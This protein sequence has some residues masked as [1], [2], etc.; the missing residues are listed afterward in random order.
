MDWNRV[1]DSM[2]HPVVIAA[3][4]A[5][6]FG[7]I[8]KIV[9]PLFKWVFP[10]IMRYLN[11]NTVPH[12]VNPSTPIATYSLPRRD[13]LE[14]I[15]KSLSKT[16][17]VV[18]TGLGGI[19]KTQLASMYRKEH[20]AEYACNCWVDASSEQSILEAYRKFAVGNLGMQDELEPEKYLEPVKQWMREHEKWLF[21][22]DNADDLTNKRK[23]IPEEL[24]GM[25]HVLFT[26]REGNW[27]EVAAALP[28]EL[29]SL[30]EAQNYFTKATGRGNNEGLDDLIEALG[31]LPLAMAQAAAFIRVE[32]KNHPE[33]GYT[34]YL[35]Q[36]KK[37]TE[38]MLRKYPVADEDKRVVYAT[39]DISME[40]IKNTKES[41]WQLLNIMAFFAPDGIQQKW[42]VQGKEALPEPLQKEIGDE[43]RWL[44]IRDA[45]TE[46]SLVEESEG[47]ALGMHRLVGEVVRDKLK[48]TKE[49]EAYA[50]YAVGVGDELCFFDF[51]TRER[52]NTFEELYPHI[53][54]VVDTC[55]LQDQDARVVRL[56]TFLG[57][58]AHEIWG[59]YDLALEWHEKAS[60][61]AEK[62]LRKEHPD[63]AV[64]YN[65]IAS[66]YNNKGKYD[67]ALKWHE[68]ALVIREKVLGK[69]HSDT[70][71]TYNN[72]AI[73][74]RN[75]GEHNLA[76]EWNEKALVIREKV[77]GKEHPLT[78]ATYNNIANVYDSKSEHDRALEWYQKAL[79]I[80]EKVLGKEHPDTAATYN[81]IANVYKDK[82]EH[83]RALEWHE[84]ALVIAEDVLGKE[85]PHTAVTY[86]NI[87]NAYKNKGEYDRALEGYE[88]ALP[89]FEKKLG[90][91]HPNTILVRN[92]IAECKRRMQRQ[93]HT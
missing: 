61:I 21:V 59:N 14:K 6:F 18:L 34:E 23:W 47:G 88:K 25:R 17:P 81:N 15:S 72:I 54:S 48:A 83:D 52:R 35:E 57:R 3:L 76:L 8:W 78:A 62:V 31:Y 36:F 60:A 64:T 28:V 24:P 20:A 73:I 26:S 50:G 87:G 80:R 70:A 5:G 30:E 84:K 53:E 68:K 43:L 2:H 82:G 42:F 46:H 56:C 22:F 69:E 91:E 10:K 93:N 51:S 58:G 33:R 4:I 11:R 40:R 86:N 1:V 45:L 89:V 55:A 71:A 12:P 27:E 75:K 7:V 67:L 41:A 49:F 37:R 32:W 19:G 63:T 92:N 38:E 39:W 29:F 13:M 90:E 74:Y 79:A 65:N 9:I 77:L 66:V 16:S 44:E 85:H